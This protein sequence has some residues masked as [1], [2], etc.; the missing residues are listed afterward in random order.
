MRG[1]FVHG[2]IEWNIDLNGESWSQGAL[3]QGKLV[4]KNK[5]SAPV[6]LEGAGVQLSYSEIKK[7]QSRD[8]KALKAVIAV[9]LDI[10]TIDSGEE[11]T[12]PLKFKLADDCGVTDAKNSMYVALGPQK[13]ESQLQ[14][15][16]TP[17][18]I[19]LEMIKL[20]ETFQR[21]KLKSFKSNKE[22]VEF[23]LTPPSSRELVQVDHLLLSM[24]L[25]EKNLLMSFDFAM[26]TLDTQGV[27][28]KVK[29]ESK[30]MELTLTPKEY[31]L[32]MDMI[33]QDVMLQR[34]ESVVKVVKGHF[35]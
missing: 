26:K 28:N 3:I 19:F 35:F 11:K 30:L 21:F 24:R 5:S 22:L 23:K 31:S 7:I 25:L 6:S 9:E 1:T 16:V 13:S 33:N 12:I 34:L 4:L 8:P 17:Q 15:H 18:K 14:V 20:L 27:T 29:K 2:P 32:G 10:S